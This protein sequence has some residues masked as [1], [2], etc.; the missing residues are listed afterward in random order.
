MGGGG[1][2]KSQHTKHEVHIS[3][4][5]VEH[6]QLIQNNEVEQQSA[7]DLLPLDASLD[8]KYKRTANMAHTRFLRR[9]DVIR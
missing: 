4:P 1:L 7:Q 8:Q 5:H 3:Y 9:L 6:I 2:W